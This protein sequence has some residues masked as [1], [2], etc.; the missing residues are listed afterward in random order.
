MRKTRLQTGVISIFLPGLIFGFV[1]AISL[2]GIG[3]FGEPGS[4][5][6]DP[7]TLIVLAADQSQLDFYLSLD[8]PSTTFAYRSL[9]PVP[10]ELNTW[11]ATNRKYFVTAASSDYVQFPEKHQSGGNLYADIPTLATTTHRPGFEGFYVHEALTFTSFENDFDWDE[12]IDEFDFNWMY[13]I[14]E[15]AESQDK[16][17]IWSEPSFAWQT[18]RQDSDAQVFFSTWESVIVPMF[19]TNFFG[20]MSNSRE[21]AKAVADEYDM[22]FGQSH[23]GWAMRPPDQPGEPTRTASFNLAKID[24]WDHGATYYQFE[25]APQDFLWNSPYMLGVRDFA[26]FIDTQ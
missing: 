16:K 6:S 10:S 25:G 22:A 15:L 1:F 8:N 17:V 12:A 2:I 11:D 7:A 26:A 5:S 21:N 9:T 14:A 18:L 13:Q 20:Q 19:G 4:E 24:G 23:Q 3:I